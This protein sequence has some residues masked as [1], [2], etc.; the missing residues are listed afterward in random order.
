MTRK[1]TA[2]RAS[3]SNGNGNAKV[4]APVSRGHVTGPFPARMPMGQFLFAYL[5]RR[6]V[7]H[8]FGVP[9]DFVLPTYAWLEK[10]PIRSITMTHEPGAGFAA[11]AYSRINGIGLV[12]VTYCVGGLN[13]LNAIAGAY[14]EKSPVVVV[15]GAPGRKDREKDPLLHHK[16]KTF[17]TQ[18]RVYDEV[19]VASTVLLDEDTAASEIVRCV[20]ACLRHKRP[21]YIEVPHDMVDR[22]IPTRQIVAPV[23]PKSDPQTLAAALAEATELLSHAK[24]PVLFAGVELHR[25]GL[26]DIAIKLAERL[27]IP[28]AADLLSKSA[29]PENHPLYIGVYGGAMSSDPYVRKYVESSDCV[30]ML[31]NFIT[32]MNL[33]IYTAKLDRNR[34]IL[35]TTE[36]IR[37]QYHR[38]EEV[39]FKDFLDGLAKANVAKKK[40]KHPHPLKDLKPLVKAELTEPLTMKEVFRIVALHLDEN[41]CVVSDV[42]DAIFGAVG[43]R[44]AKRAEFIA[45]AYYLS[46]GFAVPAS[47]GVETA[48]PALR[49]VV[50]VGDGAFQMTGTELSTAVRLGLKPIVLVLNNEGYG[51]MRKIRDG[52]F[53]E[54][55]QWDYGK[56]CELIG[57]GTAVCATTRGE[58]DGAIRSAMGSNSLRVIDVKIPRDDMSP[59]L[60]TMSAELARLRGIKK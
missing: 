28:I 46:M 42:G 21:V 35:A 19:T 41:C 3:G 33:G 8:S 30:L 25:F 32:D 57:G 2:H 36:A 13:V 6:G 1:P 39:E 5:H 31:G 51:T 18:R 47:I 48:N 20:E 44:T 40:F 22:E 38:Y 26:T 23:V 52:Y 4:A 50:L 15:S 16:V 10:S 59:Q 56:I 54:I 12:C 34:T 58:L 45:P 29:V 49:P 60:A 9:G 24:K 11:D 17:E 7:R 14:A 43:I 37:V 55:S 27:N 53:N